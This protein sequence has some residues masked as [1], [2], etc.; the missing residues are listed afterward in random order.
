MTALR[1]TPHSF[2]CALPPSPQDIGT[3]HPDSN[4]HAIYF[5]LYDCQ[6]GLLTHRI[7][8]RPPTLLIDEYRAFIARVAAAETSTATAAR[9]EAQATH[10]RSGQFGTAER[11]ATSQGRTLRSA[12]AMARDSGNGQAA[13]PVIDITTDSEGEGRSD[14]DDDEDEPNVKSGN[15]SAH[16]TLGPD[17]DAQP[18]RATRPIFAVLYTALSTVSLNLCHSMCALCRGML[19]GAM[20]ALLG[21]WIHLYSTG[22][23]VYSYSRPDVLR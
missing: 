6:Q 18:P 4:L 21:A 13:A 8:K 20:W 10:G 5:L 9:V 1:L 12:T 7:L 15:K 14:G 11:A 2:A 17:G 3:S 23:L 19:K 16:R 22:G